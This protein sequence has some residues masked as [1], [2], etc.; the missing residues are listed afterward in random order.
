MTLSE[1]KEYLIPALNGLGMEETVYYAEQLD[2][3]LGI[4]AYRNYAQGRIKTYLT[5]EQRNL[6]RALAGPHAHTVLKMWRIR[7]GL[8]NATEVEANSSD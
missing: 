4:T 7:K 6:Y 1:V 3:L 2:D 8:E 5:P